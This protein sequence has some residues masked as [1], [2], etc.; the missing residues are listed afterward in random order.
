MKALKTHFEQV[1]VETVKCLADA[2]V[3]EKGKTV[4][5]EVSPPGIAKKDRP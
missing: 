5:L 4:K 2:E 3:V 1:P